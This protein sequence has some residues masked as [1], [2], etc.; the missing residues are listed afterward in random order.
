MKELLIAFGLLGLAVLLSL[1]QPQSPRVPFETITAGEKSG[2]RSQEE[3]VIT[4]QGQ[5]EALWQQHMSYNRNPL[6]V[7]H[8]YF[9]EELVVAV[10]GGTK[11][12]GY[13]LRI[14]GIERREG[15]LMIY[16]IL[17]GPSC[18]KCV[19][20]TGMVQ[21]FHIVKLERQELPVVFLRK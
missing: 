6:P 20:P 3:L 10:L 18:T 11:S 17:I 4:D 8:V 16:Y 7:P 1:L 12:E 21:P 9:T 15:Q 19:L 13:M 2:I 14:T 5:W